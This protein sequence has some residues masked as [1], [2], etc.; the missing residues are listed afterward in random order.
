MDIYQIL[1]TYNKPWSQL[2][3]ACF[4]RGLIIIFICMS[5]C[6]Y[7][8]KINKIQAATILL[9]MVFLS[10]VFESTIFT[11]TV[12]VRQYKLQLFWLW[13]EIISYHNT[14]LLKEVLLNCILLLPFGMLLPIVAGHK[15]AWYKALIVGVLVSAFIE[16]SQLVLMRGLFEWDDMIHNGLG[17]MAGCCVTNFMIGKLG[18]INIIA[19]GKTRSIKK[20]TTK[21]YKPR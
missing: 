13:R 20:R 18:K 7:K 1:T 11:R 10:I 16:V 12:T 19:N 21:N 17:C 6:V 4:L 3:T 5:Y 9:M 14:E 8:K 2:E 15:L